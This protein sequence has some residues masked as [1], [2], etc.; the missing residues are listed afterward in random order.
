MDDLQF[1]TEKGTEYYYNQETSIVYPR[2]HVNTISENGN[3]K[4]IATEQNLKT[5]I[6]VNGLNQL[7][8]IVGEQ[9][10]LGCTYCAYSGNYEQNRR[11][12]REVMNY[13][14]A[15]KAVDEYLSKYI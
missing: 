4:I 14:I 9:C 7:I 15:K 10:N 11:H 3:K 6:N 1:E 12:T 2:E 5:E 8:L 13:T